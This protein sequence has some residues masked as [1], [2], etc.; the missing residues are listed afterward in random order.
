MT[1]NLKN[2]QN[3]KVKVSRKISTFFR[4]FNLEFRSFNSKLHFST[5]KFPIIVSKFGGGGGGG[6]MNRFDYNSLT[7]VEVSVWDLKS[8]CK[9]A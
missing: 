4:S 2:K 9:S 8:Q 7:L 5:S 6:G 3:F 1:A